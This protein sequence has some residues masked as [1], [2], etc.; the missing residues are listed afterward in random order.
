MSAPDHD[1]RARTADERRA[2]T[3]SQYLTLLAGIVFVAIGVAG[4]FVTGFEDFAQHDTGDTIMGFEVNPLHNTVH[5][6]LGVLGLALF[7]SIRGSL[8]YGLI[9]AIG[10]GATFVFGLFAIGEEW[11]IL[12]LN[13]AD[14]WLHLGLTALGVVIAALAAYELRVLRSVPATGRS[15]DVTR[16]PRRRPA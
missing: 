2:L 13:T 5:L 1:S 14:N 4:F 16:S 7:M 10:Y 9:T 3:P 15:R 8:T 6:V 12:S 11:N